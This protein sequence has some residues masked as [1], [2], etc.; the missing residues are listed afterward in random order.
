M[1][2]CVVSSPGDGPPK[3]PYTIIE[4][5]RY[6]LVFEMA[7]KSK[8]PSIVSTALDCLQVVYLNYYVVIVF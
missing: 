7:C 6:F 8:S 3:S 4:A 5:D 2:D 1:Y